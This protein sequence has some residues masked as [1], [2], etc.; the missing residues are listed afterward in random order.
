MAENP[1]RAEEA[2]HDA[3]SLRRIIDDLLLSL[4]PLPEP[5]TFLTHV[6]M[7]ADVEKVPFDLEVVLDHWWWLA[8][9]GVIG[10]PGQLATTRL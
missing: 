8:R 9:V 5:N 10:F 1:E 6:Q 3:E 7:R 2:R 4:E